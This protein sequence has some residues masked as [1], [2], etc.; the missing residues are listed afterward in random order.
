MPLLTSHM[1]TVVRSFLPGWTTLTWTT[2]NI[3]AFLHR[4]EGSVGEFKAVV[5][6][7]MD[8]LKE[9]VYGSLETIRKMSLFDVELAASRMW[10]SAV[11]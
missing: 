9:G 6:T 1:D 8:V 2:M 10:V 7:V 5:T 3:D 11:S 4:M